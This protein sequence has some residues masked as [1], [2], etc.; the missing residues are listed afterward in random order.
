MSALLVAERWG[1]D[2]APDRFVRALAHG[3]SDALGESSPYARCLNPLLHALGW[4]GSTR[5]L[6]EILPHCAGDIGLTDLRN[7]LATV[8]YKSRQLRTRMADLDSRLLPCLFV[9]S[10]NGPVLVLDRQGDLFT[11]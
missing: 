11:L 6:F 10:N 9:K 1:G 5:H 7:I 3:E 2:Q 4:R 8:N